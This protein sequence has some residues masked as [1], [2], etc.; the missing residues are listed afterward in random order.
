M[1]KLRYDYEERLNAGRLLT[2]GKG[3]RRNNLKKISLKEK[4]ENGIAVSTQANGRDFPQEEVYVGNGII[5]IRPWLITEKVLFRP[6]KD[7]LRIFTIVR[8]EKDSKDWGVGLKVRKIDHPLRRHFHFTYYSQ[9]PYIFPATFVKILVLQK[10]Y[11]VCEVPEAPD[12]VEV[13]DE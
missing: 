7:F 9:F 6:D 13:G 5:K 4:I 10:D 8:V 2:V 1:T 3:E 11:I 12:P